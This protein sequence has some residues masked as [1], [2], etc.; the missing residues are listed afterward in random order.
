MPRNSSPNRGGSLVGN[1]RCQFV[2]NVDVVISVHRVNAR[3]GVRQAFEILIKSLAT[4]FGENIGWLRDHFHLQRILAF[5]F[6]NKNDAITI[7]CSGQLST[8]IKW[9]LQWYG[10]VS[11]CLVASPLNL[12]ENGQMVSFEKS[13]FQQGLVFVVIRQPG[14]M[15]LTSTFDH[16]HFQLR[17]LILRC[18]R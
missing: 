4:R 14:R 5:P 16:A 15:T 18:R 8:D 9:L 7:I 12:S 17:K 11:S 13:T 2:N 1:V 10:M 3:T 6:V